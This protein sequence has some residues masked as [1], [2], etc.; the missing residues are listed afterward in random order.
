[1]KKQLKKLFLIVL[2]GVFVLSSVG[3]VFATEKP[4]EEEDVYT[5]GISNFRDSFEF[6]WKVH[7]NIE[8]WAEKY[9]IK[10]CLRTT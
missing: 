7:S 10:T 6:C 8:E 2:C 3:V 9:G 1:M 4:E 5:L